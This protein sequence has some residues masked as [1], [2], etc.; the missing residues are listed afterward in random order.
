MNMYAVFAN[1]GL[2]P[3]S[4]RPLMPD[5]QHAGLLPYALLCHVWCG[6][7]LPQ[8][9]LR[10]M[11][12]RMSQPDRNLPPPVQEA[13]ILDLGEGHVR[14]LHDSLAQAGYTPEAPRALWCLGR[15]GVSVALFPQGKL[16]VLGSGAKR[17]AANLLAK[18]AGRGASTSRSD[19]PAPAAGSGCASAAADVDLQ[20][21]IARLRAQ[22]S[23]LTD[24]RE[25]TG[26]SYADLDELLK[27]PGMPKRHEDRDEMIRGLYREGKTYDEISK[28]LS[29]GLSRERVRQILRALGEVT[30]PHQRASQRRLEREA[31][32][33]ED[34]AAIENFLLANPGATVQDVSAATGLPAERVQ[35]VTPDSV[36]SKLIVPSDG[37]RRR[38]AYSDAQ[39]IA[40]IRQAAEHATPL[41]C[42]AYTALR[43]Q[44]VVHGPTLAVI[45][46]RIGSW[47]EACRRAG[48]H[49][50]GLS[51]PSKAQFDE[52]ACLR[53]VRDYLESH[54]ATGTVTGYE[55]WRKATCPAAPSR[56]TVMN[57]LGTTNW[58]DIKKQ[59][60]ARR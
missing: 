11:E 25:Q 16:V 10:T 31:S 37:A 13:V 42:E 19:A 58:P 21:L 30:K 34:A 60:L 32:H 50:G 22:G 2:T 51:S 4:R 17:V 6:T 53:F 45:F 26:L 18:A 14:G 52:Q 46:R 12:P 56:S 43:S 27:K 5:A 49:P 8:S 1:A 3:T 36:R 44:G 9:T 24:I 39:I 7:R 59:A 29:L 55:A 41:T 15:G 40:A 38:E 54:G 35:Q 47:P 23:T 48:A 57:Q 33:R 28:L 20:V